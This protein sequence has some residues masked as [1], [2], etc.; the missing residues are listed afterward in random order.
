[1]TQSLL[2]TIESFKDALTIDSALTAWSQGAYGRAQKVYVNID[3]R[4]P[5]GESDC[6][7]ILLRP[8][9]AA[10]G[11]GVSQK[12]LNI[13]LLCCLYDEEFVQD[14]ETNAVEYYGVV[15]CMQM[16]DLAVAAIAAVDTGNSLLQDIEAE[17]ETIEFFPFFMAGCPLTMA[18]PITLGAVRTTL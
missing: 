2:T 1:M 3:V 18:E 6:P 4:N 5:P 10:Y 12:T 14:P 17:F 16:L 13:E 15:N 11:R 8:V 7:Y 9:S